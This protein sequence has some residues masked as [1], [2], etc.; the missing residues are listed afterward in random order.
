MRGHT[1]SFAAAAALAATL[2][3]RSLVQAGSPLN[4]EVVVPDSQASAMML[5]LINQ[6]QVLILDKVEG[7]AAKLPNGNPVWGSIMNLT[8]NSIRAVQ[9]NTNT[10]S[11]E[12]LNRDVIMLC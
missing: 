2:G 11:E 4:Y 12:W 9:V 1:K 8:D 10:V 5:G 3:T 7:N 6:D